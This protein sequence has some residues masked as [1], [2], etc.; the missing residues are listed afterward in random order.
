M[1]SNDDQHEAFMRLF[2]DNEHEVLRYV[3]ALVPNLADA[4]DIVQE[5]AVSL[6]KRF[7]AYDREQPFAPWACRFSLNKIRHHWRREKRKQKLFDQDTLD[8]LA[9]R[10]TERAEELDYRREHL[11]DCLRKMPEK[12]R[13]V[14][15][16]YYFHEKTVEQ[17]SEQ[18]GRTVE[19]IYKALQRIRKG[20]M[21]CIETKLESSPQT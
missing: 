14:I 20:L 8:F 11:N 13:E 3:L 12:S 17:L 18:T 19:A 9:H 1:P 21:K 4:R 6:W 10:R 15:T 7:D 16:G 2:L 5:T